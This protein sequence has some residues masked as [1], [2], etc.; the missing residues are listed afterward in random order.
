MFKVEDVWLL[1]TEFTSMSIGEVKIL[2]YRI[3]RKVR[4]NGLQG[5]NA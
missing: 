2:M 5:K 1:I 4:K 3:W